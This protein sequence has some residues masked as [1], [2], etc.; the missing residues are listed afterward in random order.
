MMPAHRQNLILERLERQSMVRVA[1]L[2]RE[3]GV[4]TE[5]IRRDLD[6]L[7]DGGLVSRTHG[8]AIATEAL[9]HDRPFRDRSTQRL[10]EKRAIARAVVDDIQPGEILGL[11][12][13]STCTVLAD[14][15]PDVA[16]TVVTN[17][18][19]IVQTLGTRPNVTIIATGGVLDPQTM[20]FAGTIAEST[21]RRF[22]FDRLFISCRGIDPNRGVGEASDELARL[23]QC[24]IEAANKV[25]ALADHTKF[26]R[27]P[28]FQCAG[29]DEI[30][31][32]ITDDRAPEAA[33]RVIRAGKRV[34]V[35]TA[36]I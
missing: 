28:A 25:Y 34:D 31:K 19:A 36:A 17:S 9:H 4:T 11:D 14:L 6:Q 35:V 18:A 16:I 29:W 27:R 22:T 10:D 1:D 5:T 13:S 12:A 23:K 7:S 3:F 15:L 26:D 2:S 20:A 32:L 21:I 33:V 8:G 24:M 30:D